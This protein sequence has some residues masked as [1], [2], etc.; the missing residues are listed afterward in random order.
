MPQ[1]AKFTLEKL[2]AALN[3]HAPASSGRL[4]GS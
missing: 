3:D 1:A 2:A 4:D